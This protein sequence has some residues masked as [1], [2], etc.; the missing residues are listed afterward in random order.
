MG[1][2]R[3]MLTKV[4]CPACK[5]YLNEDMQW[6]LNEYSYCHCNNCNIKINDYMR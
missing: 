2:I 4:K 3:D 5:K 6:K 1:I